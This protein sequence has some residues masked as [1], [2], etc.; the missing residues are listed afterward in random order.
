MKSIKILF[1]LFNLLQ[2]SYLRAQSVEDLLNAQGSN[3]KEYVHNTFKSSR[4]VNLASTEMIPKRTLELRISH[5]MGTIDNG[6]YDIFGLDNATMRF[7]FDY[8]ITNRIQIGF[9]RST[10]EKTYDFSSK[11]S[12]LRQ[13]YKNN[14]MPISLLINGNASINTL[15]QSFEFFENKHRMEYVAQIIIARKFGE[16]FSLQCSPTFTHRNLVESNLDKNDN[17]A[18][19][20]AARIKLS[21]RVHI[22]AEYI[23][24]IPQPK[25]GSFDKEY[26]KDAL[27]FGVDLDTGG[28]IFQLFFTNSAAFNESGVVNKTYDSWSKSKFRF[29]FNLTRQ[30]GF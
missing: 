13:T 7:G 11:I 30:F 20:T 22:T 17:F 6:F 23:A 3:E 5:R 16:I 4:I 12:L 1:V 24:R 2:I 8:G 21:N 14:S 18:L 28:H 19:G 26:T 25:E 29:G 10:F 9:G 27:S 15:K